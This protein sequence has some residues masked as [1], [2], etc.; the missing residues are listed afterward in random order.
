M[1]RRAEPWQSRLSFSFRRRLRVQLQAEAAECGLACLAMIVCWHGHETDVAALRRRFATSAQGTTL[2][3]LVSI[4]ARMRFTCRP[5]RLELEELVALRLP[6]ILHWN[7]NHYVVLTH[8]TRSAIRIADPARGARSLSLAEAGRHFTGVALE[9]Q[10]AAGFV[11]RRSPPSL[12]LAALVAGQRGLRASLA[13]V[14][15]LALALEAVVLASPFFMQWVVD[16]AIVSGDRDLLLLL[17]LGFGLLLLVQAATAGA[18]SLVILHASTHLSLHWNA[19]LFAHLLH[20]PVA[21]FERRHV[22]DVVSRFGSLA[23]L[24]RTLTTGFVEAVIDGLMAV[25]TLALMLLY[26]ATLASIAAAA[27]LL[28]ALIRWGTYRPLRSAAEEQVVFAARAESVFI[29]SVRAVATIKLANHEDARQARWMNATVDATNRST[30]AETMTIAVRGA[31]TLLSGGEHLLIV[32]LGATA[33]IDGFLSV[34]ML[35]AFVAYR[36]AFS[37]RVGALVDRWIQF[38]MLD[39]HRARLA[40]IALEPREDAADDPSA[41]GEAGDAT[42]EAVGVSFRYGDDEP[43]VLRDVHLRIPAGDCVA[44]TG[45]SGC[46]KTTL[47]KILTGLL[48]PT[49]G[50]VRIAGVAGARTGVQAHRRRVAAVLQDDQLLAGSIEANIAFFEPGPDRT[51][52]EQCARIA[53]IHDEIAAMPMGYETLVGDMG[54]SLSGGQK[55]RVLLARAL[56]RQPDVLFLDEATSHLDVR[57]ECLINEAIRRLPLTR[58]VVAHRPQTIASADRVVVLEGGAIKQD[59]RVSTAAGA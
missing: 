56:Y 24:Q 13:Q 39:L 11:P 49:S 55:Q 29:E 31:Q 25:A 59:L 36:A 23:T 1:N 20:L 16:G 43:W 33:V 45:A 50:E 34:G 12:S 8:A 10:P 42:I 21:W 48:P 44:I 54:A 32:T 52:V 51:R 19:S 15:V 46:G 57:R 38:R 28:Y 5:L 53:A 27:A 4:A 22:G 2:R 18:R 6:C 58:V 30:A 47:L 7:L 17:A 9:L 41:R 14:L 37:S 3:Q 26:S 40:D 35:L